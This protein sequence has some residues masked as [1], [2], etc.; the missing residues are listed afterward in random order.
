MNAY[1]YTCISP[2]ELTK[3]YCKRGLIRSNG[4]KYVRHLMFVYFFFN[5]VLSVI[6]VCTMFEEISV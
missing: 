3:D 5:F 1:S 4:T 2:S 6:C